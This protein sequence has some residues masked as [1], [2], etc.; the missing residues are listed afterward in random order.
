[1]EQ[2]NGLVGNQLID[3]Q[4][5]S[6]YRAAETAAGRSPS[7]I[8]L[9]AYYLARI[10][11]AG[12]TDLPGLDGFLAHP[13]W[14]P[15]TRRSAAS[16]VASF[17]R[18]ARRNQ[19]ACPDPADI[20][21]PRAVQGVPRPAPDA[22]VAAAVASADPDT[23][24]MLLLAA[25]CGL[26]RAEIAG[27]AVGD[28]VADHLIVRGKGRRERILPCPPDIGER[29][30]SRDGPWLFPSPRRAGRPVT[31]DHV[32]R[33][34]SAVLPEGVTCHRLR[35]R[36]ASRAY[37]STGDIV[38][39]QRA[40]GHASVATTMVYA[41]PADDALARVVAAAHVDRPALRAV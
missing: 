23:A 20:G 27:L 25:E 28:L 16:A 26:R 31:P 12:V 5:I 41:A 24:L 1:M 17:L 8:R 18:W 37:Q 9:R 38:A 6:L 33:R 3:D 7:T 21:R 36:F 34:V 10:A 32:G 39:V 13:S 11:A 29:I 2:I 40:L 14:R 19:I 15:N 35:H 30:R 4:R 22:A